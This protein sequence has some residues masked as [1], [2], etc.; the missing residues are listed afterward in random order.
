M[1]TKY[2]DIPVKMQRLDHT[3]DPAPLLAEIDAHPELWDQNRERKIG[4]DNPHREAPD[5]WIRCHDIEPSRRRGTIRTWND[6]AEGIWYP[7]YYALP[8]VIPI[9]FDILRDLWATRLGWVLI[10]KVPPGKEIHAHIDDGWNVKHH[11]T[12]VYAVLQ[13]N[14][15]CVNW[16]E[17]QNVVM[18]AGECWLFNNQLLHGLRNAGDTDRISMMV[19]MRTI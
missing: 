15:Q 17:D 6:Q 18:K 3:F 12:K 10:T 4:T 13:S 16:V 1:I 9:I 5:I 19:T 11:D 14:P 7:G 8:A 2:P